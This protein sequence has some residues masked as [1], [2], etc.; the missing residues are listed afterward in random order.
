MPRPVSAALATEAAK[1][2]TSF[3][4][5]VE[6]GLPSV[7]RWSNIGQVTYD[8]QTWLD[9]DFGLDGVS[10][11]PDAPLGARL[12]VQNLAPAAGESARIAEVLVDPAVIPANVTVTVYQ[13]AY[14]ALAAGDAPKIATMAI[15]GIDFAHDVVTISL[16]ESKDAASFCPRR[17]VNAANGFKFATPVGTVIPWEGEVFV[18]EAPNG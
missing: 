7:R 14:G 4:Y 2:I 1:V 18:A 6:L 9:V 12:S 8:G 3:G 16:S 17:R 10:L 15:S 5:L 13:F 11:D